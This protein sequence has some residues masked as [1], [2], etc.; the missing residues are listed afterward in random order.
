MVDVPTSQQPSLHM[1]VAVSPG[2]FPVSVTVPQSGLVK[3]GHPETGTTI[4]AHHNHYFLATKICHT[5]IFIPPHIVILICGVGTMAVLTG[6]TWTEK[7][8]RGS[9]SSLSAMI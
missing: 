8:S 6:V 3:V 1:N 2:E 5:R 4:T 7:T 9:V